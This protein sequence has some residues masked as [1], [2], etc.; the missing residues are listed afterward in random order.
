MLILLL[1]SFPM[2]IRVIRFYPHKFLQKAHFRLASSHTQQWCILKLSP[3][4]TV[5][6]ETGLDLRRA[7]KGFQNPLREL[8]CCSFSAYR[9]LCYLLKQ[10][11]TTNFTLCDCDHREVRETLYSSAEFHMKQCSLEN[12]ALS[13]VWLTEKG[14]LFCL[15][16]F[17]D[18][19]Q[20]A[21]LN[22]L[23]SFAKLQ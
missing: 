11:S 23:L 22:S 3:E 2:N 4:F 19:V 10:G 12:H 8:W 9:I 5:W 6:Y 21:N 13:I 20:Q 1:H 7:D 17:E 16:L 15:A 14:F 18:I